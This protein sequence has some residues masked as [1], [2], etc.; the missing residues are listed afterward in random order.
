[1]IIKFSKLVLSFSLSLSLSVYFS[2][3]VTHTHTHTHTPQ[4]EQAHERRFQAAQ[5]EKVF[6]CLTY[7]HVVDLI[8]PD[9]SM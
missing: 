7:S 4:E 1:M 5:A 2:L 9:N 6:A 8:I 3:S